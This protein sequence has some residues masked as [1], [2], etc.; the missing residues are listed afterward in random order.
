MKGFKLILAS[1][2]IA[3]GA[4]GYASVMAYA[5]AQHTITEKGKVFSQADITI[6]TGDTVVFVNDD[7]IAHNVMSND[8]GNKFNLGLLQ[9]GTSTP[10]TFDKAGEAT[11]LCAIHPS[12]KMHVKINN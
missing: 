7:N 11:I 9:P 2:F 4:V 10:V 8:E 6:K 12:M 3:G 5:G 1:A